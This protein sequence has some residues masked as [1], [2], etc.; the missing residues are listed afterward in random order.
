LSQTLLVDLVRSGLATVRAKRVRT[1]R[2]SIDMVLV[3]IGTAGRE[4][5][6]R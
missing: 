6:T 4:R 1:G 3:L 5:L 2:Q